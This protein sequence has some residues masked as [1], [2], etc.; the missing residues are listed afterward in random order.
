MLSIP[1]F[2]FHLMALIFW[3]K[4]NRHP[5]LYSAP[6][7]VCPH[8]EIIFPFHCIIWLHS[9]GYENTLLLHFP[10][11]ILKLNFT[12]SGIRWERGKWVN[13]FTYSI[14]VHIYTLLS[15]FFNTMYIVYCL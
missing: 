8:Q 12:I 4:S 13:L 10:P 3:L 5:L 14:S 11:Q 1:F 15:L 9:L 7:D 6:L 2:Y